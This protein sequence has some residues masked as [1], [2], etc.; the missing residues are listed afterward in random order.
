MKKKNDSEMILSDKSVQG[1]FSNLNA[2]RTLPR[3]EAALHGHQSK[4]STS[5]KMVVRVKKNPKKQLLLMQD[6]LLAK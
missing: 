2:P 6:T 5:V 4:T 3:Y 1:L